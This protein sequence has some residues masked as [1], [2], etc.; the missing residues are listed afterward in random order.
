MTAFYAAK[1][2][3]DRQ[4]L[5]VAHAGALPTVQRIRR[6]HHERPLDPAAARQPRP[7][8]QRPAGKRRMARRAGLAAAGRRAAARAR[9]HGHAGADG[10]RPGDR[11]AAGARH[12]LRQHHPGGAAAGLPGRPGDRGAPGLADALERA[13]DGGARQPGARRTGRPHRQLRQRGRPV[14]GRLQPLLPRRRRRGRRRP[15]LLP[16][17]LG[18]GRLCARLP[19]RPPERGR[20]GALPAGDHARRAR[21]ARP[22]ELPASLADAG[23]LAVP[24]R[25]D[26]PRADQLDLPGALHALPAAPRPAGH[27]RAARSG[28]CSATARWTSPRA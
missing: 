20:P 8:R 13:G 4:H 18:A 28:A 27:Q 15:G 12:A 17:A 1:P 24:H 6:S 7:R 16:A 5:R 2:A 23:L 11:L 3:H 19:R 25:L 9:D 26:G 21:R 14:R 22:V 10:A